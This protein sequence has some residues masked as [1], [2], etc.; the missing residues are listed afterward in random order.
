MDFNG[1]VE[2]RTGIFTVNH[3][4]VESEGKLGST[5]YRRQQ[6][7]SILVVLKVL[8]PHDG[9]LVCASQRLLFHDAGISNHMVEVFQ[10]CLEFGGFVPGEF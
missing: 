1:F 2:F 4:V 9:T 8:D 3:M 7:H 6:V 10:K 5:W